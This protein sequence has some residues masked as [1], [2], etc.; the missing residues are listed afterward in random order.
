M[1]RT[2]LTT[3]SA[4]I[5]ALALNGGATA[6]D[7]AE[8]IEG[9]K[10]AVDGFNGKISGG[11]QYLG[12]SG[13]RRGGSANLAFLDGSLSMPL[14]ERF[15]LQL[16]VGGAFSSTLSAGGVGLHAFWRDP[17]KALVGVY[18]EIF[19]ASLLPYSVYRI[20]AEGE[21]YLG[22]VSVEAFAGVQAPT[23]GGTPIF[24]GDLTAAF[25]PTDNIRVSAGVA[26]SFFQT[27]GTAGLEVAIPR[28]SNVLPA[29]FVDGQANS[30]FQT[31]RAGLRLYFGNSDKSLIR[32]HR[33]DDPRD[34]LDDNANAYCGMQPSN[35]AALKNGYYNPCEVDF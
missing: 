27:F 21:A 20:G 23:S 11:Y 31:V 30:A 24:T 16:D 4:A 18:G 19:T 15:G 32:R 6:A 13:L 22:R 34:R 35:P 3:V 14:G 10:P 8:R 7:L 9:L 33:E 12:L 2:L 28:G 5:L 25:Y 26:R 17:D 29:V 1:F